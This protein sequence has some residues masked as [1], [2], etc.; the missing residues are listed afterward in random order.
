MTL[1]L[2]ATKPPIEA[3]DLE[4]VPAMMSTSSVMPKC[5]AVPSPL[6]PSTPSA[7]ASSRARAAPYFRAIRDQA[8]DVGD[9][10]FH[11]VD[12]VH[13]DHRAR[14][15]A[16]PLQP[17]L[18]VAEVAVIEALGF[19]VGQLGAVHDRGVV[20]LVEVDHLAATDESRDEPQ[21]GRIAGRED[22]A[23]LLA[24]E[25]GEGAPRAARAG[26]GCR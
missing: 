21:V 8:G 19:A 23:G 24:E 20:E 17:A 9:V 22:E 5:A 14:G 1:S 18:E 10:A 26:R 16:V 11:R 13:H 2:A 6:G 4:K 12:A 15:A 3:S 25:L 7:C